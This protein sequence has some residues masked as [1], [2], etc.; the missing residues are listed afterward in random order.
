LQNHT[1]IKI[2]G[3]FNFAAPNPSLTS[4]TFSH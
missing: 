4:S 3:D 1:R 2:K